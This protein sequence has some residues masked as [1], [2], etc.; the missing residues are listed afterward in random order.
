MRTLA[1][2]RL[3][4]HSTLDAPVRDFAAVHAWFCDLDNPRPLAGVDES[5]VSSD[6]LARAERLVDEEKRRRFLRGRA[7]VRSVIGELLGIPARDVEFTVDPEGKPRVV[8]PRTCG[9]CAPPPLHV[10]WSRSQDVLLLA[11]TTRGELGVDVEISD[12]RLDLLALAETHFT[13]DEQASLRALPAEQRA[14]SF[15]RC[16]T[17]K[18]AVL[19]ALGLGL[20]GALHRVVARTE[21]H[22]A[23]CVS[24]DG[25]ALD[26]PSGWQIITSEFPVDSRR[27]VATI[28]VKVNESI[29]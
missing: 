27:A 8:Q 13:S 3:V 18:E 20:A 2:T 24:L 11:A 5:A 1:D 25:K 22:G 10:N 14:A 28:V 6:E 19:K 9:S 21:L 7:T 26:A 17:A 16:W 29:S 4:L 15:F 12:P 23:I